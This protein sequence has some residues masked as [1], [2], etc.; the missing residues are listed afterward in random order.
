MGFPEAAS[1]VLYSNG[2]DESEQLVLYR[3]HENNGEE[4][5]AFVATTVFVVTLMRH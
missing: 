5:Q 1:N 4:N 2:F 3:C